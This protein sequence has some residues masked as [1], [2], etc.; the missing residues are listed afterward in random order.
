RRSRTN[1]RSIVFAILTGNMSVR[2]AFE[3]GANFVLYKP[4]SVERAKR[5]L[6]AAHGMMMRERRRHF[7]HPMDSR[8]YLSFERVKD[9]QATI[10]DL[11]S[12]GMAIKTMEPLALRHEVHLR[13]ALPGNTSFLEG[14]GQV[15]WV[16]AFGRAGLQFTILPPDSQSE[17]EKWLLARATITQAEDAL[18]GAKP[19]EPRPVENP[20]PVPMV[21]AEEPTPELPSALQGELEIEVV[22]PEAPALAHRRW[23]E[24]K[25]RTVLR[26]ET[27]GRI[28][29]AVIRAGKVVVVRGRCE[30]LS[31]E[32]LGGEMEGEF[33][34]GDPVLLQLT[35]P[36]S[37]EPL[38]MHA[39]VRHRTE[40]YYGFEFVALDAA[41]RR[42]IR[43][44]C[45][46]LPVR[47]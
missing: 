9:L 23:R 40:N 8:V 14:E 19:A 42:V 30:D 29:A 46:A 41:Q 20:P 24:D 3:L 7:R 38:R 44:F 5:S 2:Q 11:S 6:R 43:R 21:P 13:F 18:V 27:E 33:L 32:G 39:E 17:L 12:G 26:G 15:A 35:L 47:G 34:L 1:Q 10:L 37:E 25:S 22:S 45:D 36:H 4:V 31:E 16:D 28:L